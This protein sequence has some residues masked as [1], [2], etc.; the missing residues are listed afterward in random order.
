M[1][2]NQSTFASHHRKL[3]LLDQLN[4]GAS[5][6]E[7]LISHSAIALINRI[8]IAEIFF[9]SGRTKVDGQWKLYCLVHNIEKLA[10]AGYAA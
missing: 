5:R 2:P 3:G 4:E 9:M 10:N 8:A 6:I 1:T 7:N